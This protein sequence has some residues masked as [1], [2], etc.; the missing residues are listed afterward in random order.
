MKLARRAALAGLLIATQARARSGLPP[1]L[2]AELPGARLHGSATLRFLGLAVYDIRLWATHVP[3]EDPLGSPLALELQYTRALKGA[4]IAQ[5]SLDEMVRQGPIPAP[6]RQRWLAE[7]QSLLPDVAAG[8][9]LTGVQRP[10]DRL[11]LFHNGRLR[12]E[13]ADADFTRQFFGIWLAPATSE[14]RMRRQLLRLG[15]S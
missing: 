15:E 7:L 5:R 11:R 2:A 10:A 9:R 1:E 13:V 3:L 12:G 8:D 4:D 14:P 6:Q